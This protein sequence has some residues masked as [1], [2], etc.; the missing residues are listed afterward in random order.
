MAY[1]QGGSVGCLSQWLPV[2][3]TA[4]WK[5]ADVLGNTL[6]EV[7]CA[8]CFFQTAAGKEQYVQYIRS[9]ASDVF[10]VLL[11]DEINLYLLPRRGHLITV[12]M[13][14]LFAIDI[15]TVT[16]C[17]LYHILCLIDVGIH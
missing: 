10:T 9:R 17:D 5:H 6:R 15:R 12:G 3:T 11:D 13:F 8:L 1:R 16:Q 2:V 7:L 14:S 4:S